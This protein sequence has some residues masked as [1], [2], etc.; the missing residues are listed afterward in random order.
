M[1]TM[2]NIERA[3]MVTYDRVSDETRRRICDKCQGKFFV[4]LRMLRVTLRRL[5]SLHSTV[6]CNEEILRKIIAAK[7]VKKMEIRYA[8]FRTFYPPNGIVESKTRIF[9]HIED[10]AKF[11]G[12]SDWKTMTRSGGR[13]Q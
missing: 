5:R 12:F 6:I 7:D 9:F 3:R 2:C 8:V 1:C 13:S 10:F 4:T 11:A